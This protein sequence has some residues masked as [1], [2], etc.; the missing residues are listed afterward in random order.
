MSALIEQNPTVSAGAYGV[1]NGYFASITEN[2][3]KNTILPTRNTTPNGWYSC[4]EEFLAYDF[5]G[6]REEFLMFHPKGGYANLVAFM[7]RIEDK[8]GLQDT[9]RV[10]IFTTDNSCV[11]S[12]RVPAWW[13]TVEV[14]RQILTIFLRCAMEYKAK[15]DN[16]EAALNSHSYIQVTRKA[17]DAFL[18]GR[19]VYHGNNFNGWVNVFNSGNLASYQKNDAYK[20]HYL[21]ERR[22]LA[23]NYNLLAYA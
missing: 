8:L 15:E 1:G 14:R 17:V 5:K 10:Q 16:F 21:K 4:R 13:N 7:K 20:D 3:E 12:F 11:S 6:Q 22:R 23:A 18:N 9:D 2:V 19:T